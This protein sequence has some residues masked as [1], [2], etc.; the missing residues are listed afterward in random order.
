MLI[1]T[2]VGISPLDF[3]S[4]CVFYFVPAYSAGCELFVVPP[5]KMGISRFCQSCFRAGERKTTYQQNR[6]QKRSGK[7]FNRIEHY[8]T[9][10]LAGF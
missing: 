10:S 9:P 5:D 6:D 7:A 3:V 2:P 1:V 8:M 4:V